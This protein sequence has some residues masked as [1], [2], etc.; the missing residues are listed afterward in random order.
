MNH[1]P[2]TIITQLRQVIS[3]ELIPLDPSVSDDCDLYQ[4]GLDSLAL[5]QLIILLESHFGVTVEST[6]LAKENF[7]SLKAITE[8]ITLKSQDA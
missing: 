5:M 8:L 7:K 6:D 3:E 4:E 1:S 2:T